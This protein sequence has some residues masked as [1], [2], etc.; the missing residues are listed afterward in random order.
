M[1]LHYIITAYVI[2][3]VI[4]MIIMKVNRAKDWKTAG[5]RERYNIEGQDPSMEGPFPV[6][7]CDVIPAPNG[8]TPPREP[9]NY[10]LEVAEGH[11]RVQKVNY[12]LTKMLAALGF[13]TLIYSLIGG[14]FLISL[15][16]ILFILTPVTIIANAFWIYPKRI[17]MAEVEAYRNRIDSELL[18]RQRKS[19]WIV[20]SAYTIGFTAYSLAFL[21]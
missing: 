10:E 1:L 7:V 9:T 12:L 19:A 2:Y 17:R 16:C 14:T 5:E 15:L 6:G 3:G 20:W 18:R 13:F 8:P 4:A 21:F 11:T